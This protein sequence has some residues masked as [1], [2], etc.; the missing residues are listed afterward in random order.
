M[1]DSTNFRRPGSNP[2]LRELVTDA[3]CGFLVTDTN[4]RVLYCNATLGHWLGR[5]PSELADGAMMKDILTRG[6]HL[7]FQT[8]IAP[9]ILLEGFARE[10]S[11][12]LNDR[13]RDA[14]LPVLLNAVLRRPKDGLPA[15]INYAFFDATE[16]TA[17]EQRLRER[18]KESEELAVI[19][20]NAKVGIIR[21][22]HRGRIKRLN[23][24]GAGILGVEPGC[25]PPAPIGR[26]L[27]LDDGTEDWFTHTIERPDSDCTFEASCNGHHYNISVGE[28]TNP[29]E[30]YAEKEYSVILRDI[31]K[32][33]LAEQRM[34]LLVGE[35]KHRIR[36]VFTVTAGLVRQSLRNA[37]AERDKLVDRLHNLAKS[38]E[39]L[40]QSYWKDASIREIF[41]PIEAQA[42]EQQRI[43]IEGPD[44][45]LVPNQF[46]ALS[47]AVHELAT[48]AR[49]YGALQADQGIV[50]IQWSVSD[51]DTRT[52]D[53]TWRESGGPQV[54]APERTGF[55]SAMI[56]RALA[57]EF[58][59]TAKIHYHP[60]GVEFAFSG[61]VRR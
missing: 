18:Q 31:S 45:L 38:H 16:R 27:S 23:P 42:G 58:E 10:V 3:P 51:A 55:G 36:N 15:R 20:R 52:I 53:F 29:E 33:V 25:L 54:V 17:F 13:G 57:A 14:P 44:L 49:K 21:C 41:A 46:K 40:T 50:E 11:C 6:S 34:E 39:I 8:Q 4:E 59:G 30:P 26:L 19:V 28:I 1:A 24:A 43:V 37:P 22:D 12:L 32:R 48:N 5:A 61:V 47:M 7:L 60:E 56:E 2:Y 9:A 35:L